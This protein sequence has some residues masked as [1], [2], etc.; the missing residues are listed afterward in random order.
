MDKVPKKKKILIVDDDAFL[1]KLYFKKFVE[2]GFEV[3]TALDGDKGIEIAKKSYPDLIMLDIQLPGIGGYEVL[4]ELKKNAVTN[5]IPVIILSNFFQK[6]DVQKFLKAGVKDYLI[7]SHFMPDEVVKKAK[8][9][10]ASKN[11]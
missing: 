1:S 10:L 3:F 6:E 4:M 2:E 11:Q 5:S 7:K 8:K 9:I